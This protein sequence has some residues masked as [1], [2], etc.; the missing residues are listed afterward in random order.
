[1]LQNDPL[2]VV[3]GVVYDGGISNINM[4][5][6]E[7]MSVLK[8]AASTAL[9]GSRGSNGVIIITTKRGKKNRNQLSFKVTQGISERGIPEYDRV[10][11]FEYYPLMWE[12]YRNSLVYAATP[13]PIGTANQTATNGIKTN[14]GYNPFNVANNDIV[15]TDG[16]LNPNAQLL[17]ADDLDWNK[18]LKSQGYRQ[19]YGLNYNGGNEKSDYFASFGYLSDKGFIIRSDLRKFTG[20]LNV[21]TQP[22]KW[23]KTG[24]NIAGTVTNSNT[25]SDA[26]STGYVNP[27]FFARNMGSIYPVYAHNQT[28]GEYMLDALGNRFYDYGNMSAIGI[29]N[30]PAGGSP[31]RHAPQETK[32]NE[33]LFKRNILSARGY[34]DVYFT[35]DLKFTTNISVDLTSYYGS[36]YDNNIIGDGAPAGRA[37]KESSTT[38]SYTFN[39]LLSYSKAIK[40]HNFSILAGH[41]NYSYNYNNFTGSRQG[42]KSFRK[43]RISEFFN[44]EWPVFIH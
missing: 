4:D 7:S 44:S 36:T 1:M 10:N 39:Q 11:A 40:E 20:R 15:R 41:E 13:V 33:Q 42:Q 31:G 38:T 2:Y 17:W 35:K 27:F 22:L 29:P 12:A 26:S 16:T 37:S 14:L 28:T 5:D 6:V 24:L 19:E 9:Y 8:D 23:F 34:A 3:D 25:A 18:D 30:R 43:Y 21:N 32:L